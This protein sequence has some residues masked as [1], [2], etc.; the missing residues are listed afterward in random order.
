MC[1]CLS[2]NCKFVHL[3]IGD[4]QSLRIIEEDFYEGKLFGDLHHAVEM[5]PS[6]VALDIL[7]SDGFHVFEDFRK[8]LQ[9]SY[10]TIV[11]FWPWSSSCWIFDGPFM[12]HR[13]RYA[14]PTWGC[15]HHDKLPWASSSCRFCSSLDHA[16]VLTQ[17]TV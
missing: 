14:I 17:S 3:H 15:Q 12:L 13:H 8:R 16:I 10:Y 5:I 9:S 4:S 2:F 11:L 6:H 7:A 1:L